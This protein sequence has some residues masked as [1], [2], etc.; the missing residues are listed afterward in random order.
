MKIIFIGPQGCGKGTQAKILSEKLRICHI[1]VGDLLRNVEGELRGKIDEVMSRGG[2][3]PDEL[4]VK[5]VKE[6]ISK[7]DCRRGFILDGFPRTLNQVRLLDGAIDIDKV[8]E[9]TLSDEEAVKRISGRVSCPKC[10]AGYNEL[11]APK[12]LESGKCDKCGEELVR[13]VDD[14][15]EAVLKRLKIYHDETEPVLGFYGEEV[16][17]VNGEQSIEKIAEDIWEKVV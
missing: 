13:R 12:S 10:G 7:D 5:M 8:V 15:E 2:L 16:V 17:K 3:V 6:R 14:T 11:T 1:S 4:A 9:I